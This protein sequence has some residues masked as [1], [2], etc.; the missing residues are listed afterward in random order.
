MSD[1]T[2]SLWTSG[3]ST[4]PAVLAGIDPVTLRAWLDEAVAAYHQ[5]MVTGAPQTVS[6]GQGDGQKSVTF[7]KV[8][9]GGL[10]HWIQQLQQALGLSR[11]RQAIG[12]RF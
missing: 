11:G 12:V 5:I 7:S 8:N 1:V 3:V 2:V 4:T 6:Y 9:A 10:A